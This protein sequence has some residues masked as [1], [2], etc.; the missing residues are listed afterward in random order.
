MKSEIL[1]MKL[2][3]DLGLPVPEKKKKKDLGMQFRTC[4]LRVFIKANAAVSCTSLFLLAKVSAVV[5]LLLSLTPLSFKLCSCLF[6]TASTV[7][8]NI[9]L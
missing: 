8:N 4:W 5:F 2:E 3:T 1:A 6:D 9:F 7:C